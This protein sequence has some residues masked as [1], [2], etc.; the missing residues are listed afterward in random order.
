VSSFS[1]LEANKLKDIC[2]PE[3]LVKSETPHRIYSEY[4]GTSPKTPCIFDL[5]IT[6]GISELSVLTFPMHLVICS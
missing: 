2:S 4:V 3:Q 1:C 5:S 6:S